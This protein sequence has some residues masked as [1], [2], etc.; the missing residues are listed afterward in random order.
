[1]KLAGT[2]RANMPLGLIDR[3]WAIEDIVKMIDKDA[4]KPGPHDP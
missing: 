1:L 2:D 4:P 3:L